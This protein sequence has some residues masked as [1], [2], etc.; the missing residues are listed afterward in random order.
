MYRLADRTGESSNSERGT[1]ACFWS[2][3][4]ESMC[5]FSLQPTGD[6]FARDNL[7]NSWSKWACIGTNKTYILQMENLDC[8]I[9]NVRV[10][11]N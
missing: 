8:R 4:Q 5:R 11:K 6:S 10:V 1:Y 3:G 7:H 2:T 9:G